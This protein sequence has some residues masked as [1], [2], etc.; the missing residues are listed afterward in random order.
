MKY[1]P[2]LEDEYA[3]MISKE[4]Q[5][6]IDESIMADVLVGA[7]WIRVPYQFT[8][9]QHALEVNDWLNAHRRGEVARLNGCFV[10]QEAK[11]AEWFILK[12]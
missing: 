9:P 11:D 6:E 12:W 7:G 3:D 4:I 10:F 8:D 2:N 5:K 1:E